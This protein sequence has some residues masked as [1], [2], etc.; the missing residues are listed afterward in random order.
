MSYIT[1]NRFRFERVKNLLIEFQLG[2]FLSLCLI[3]GGT[4]QDILQ[5]KLF[6]YIA[7]IIVIAANLLRSNR[8][9]NWKVFFFPIL[10]LTIILLA[11]FLQ[12]IPLPPDLWSDIPGRSGVAEGFD[13]LGVNKPWLP[14]SLTPEITKFSLL[15]FLPPIAIMVIFANGV[16]QAT[17]INTVKCI[18]SVAVISI[19]LGLLQLSAVHQ[20]LYFYE[21][22]NDKSLVGFFSNRNHLATLLLVSLPFAVS[23]AYRETKLNK[24]GLPLALPLALVLGVILVGSLFGYVVIIPLIISSIFLCT[25]QKPIKNAPIYIFSALVLILIAIDT[26]FLNN[27]LLGLSKN[28]TTLTLDQRIG[29]TS[30]T[31]KAA[32]D[33]FPFGA[34]LGSFEDV[35]RQYSHVGPRFVNHAHNDFIE[36]LL[37]FGLFG[38]VFLIFFTLYLIKM[39]FDV[40]R[41]GTQ[42]SSFAWPSLLGIG[43][44]FFHSLVDY[45]LRTIGISTLFT[46]CICLVHH[47][48]VGQ[49]KA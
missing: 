21:V 13:K 20:S 42:V 15:D 19:L 14:L 9:S 26:F 25:A 37:E 43:V 17:V 44:I 31:Y 49:N 8:F 45:P 39:A 2:I 41:N 18:L 47:G 36:T 5:P 29:F 32:L 34:G 6:I 28:L 4:S 27:Y 40:A 22:T 1:T 38:A 10:G 12:L 11:C 35:Y 23:L 3:L 48:L 46:F 30:N 7:S 33:Y 24:V 16:N